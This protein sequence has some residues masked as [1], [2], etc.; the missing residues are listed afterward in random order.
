MDTL[1]TPAT[2]TGEAQFKMIENISLVDKEG[3]VYETTSIYKHMVD[4]F[5]QGGNKI[6][7]QGFGVGEV[8]LGEKGK[9]EV[10]LS[11]DE[12]ESYQQV[13]VQR[14]LISQTNKIKFGI[15]GERKEKAIMSLVELC[16]IDKAK[17]SNLLDKMLVESKVSYKIIADG[18]I[19][20][21]GGEENF[22]KVQATLRTLVGHDEVISFRVGPNDFYIKP[23]KY[24]VI[25]GGKTEIQNMDPSH[26]FTEKVVKNG[27]ESEMKMVYVKKDKTGK[28][29]T[30][31][32]EE[33]FA[34]NNWF[35]YSVFQDNF[36]YDPKTKQY[37]R[38]FKKV[39]YLFKDNKKAVDQEVP[40]HAEEV[41]Q[42]AK[43]IEEIFSN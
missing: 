27:E 17:A 18:D 33:R 15:T 41:Q 7:I 6:G 32:A 28:I 34:S 5:G 36:Q 16:G 43:D 22:K 21:M 35:Q 25:V 14:A 31:V 4:M 3:K 42:D 11:N 29:L 39:G 13:Y 2:K 40:S 37:E 20:E 38:G 30:S 1:T 12:N 8:S 24:R 19:Q 9:L 26:V 23:D 10:N